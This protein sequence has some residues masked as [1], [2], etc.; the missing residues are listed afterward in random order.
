MMMNLEADL[1]LCITEEVIAKYASIECLT[2]GDMLVQAMGYNAD[3]ILFCKCSVGGYNIRWC[4]ENGDK[5]CKTFSVEELLNAM[6][7]KILK[8]TMEVRKDG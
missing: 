3:C 8:L 1:E 6:K 5:Y 2:F 4:F 7:G